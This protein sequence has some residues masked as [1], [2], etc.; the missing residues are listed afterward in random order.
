[1][2]VE[3]LQNM[4]KMK[5]M[6]P[7][8]S[9]LGFSIFYRSAYISLALSVF[10]SLYTFARNSKPISV[11]FVDGFSNYDWR[12]ITAVT[13]WI[14]EKSGRFK[15]D[16]SIPDDSIDHVSWRPEFHTY[17]VVIQNMNNIL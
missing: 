10:S 8:S 3:R 7:I 6:L 1:M 9:K 12:Q 11:L 16:V 2:N 15:V 5:W 13:K 4:F 14:L 17:A